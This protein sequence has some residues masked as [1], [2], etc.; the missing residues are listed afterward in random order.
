MNRI[1]KST[2]QTIESELTR[3]EDCSIDGPLHTYVYKH[4]VPHLFRIN[5]LNKAYQYLSDE[6][7]LIEM[8][9]RWNTCTVIFR[10]FNI[11]GESL[12]R[13]WLRKVKQNRLPLSKWIDTI[14]LF[15]CMDRYYVPTLLCEQLQKDPTIFTKVKDQLN[16]LHS[17]LTLYNQLAHYDKM[18]TVG[19]QI[20]A[21]VLEHPSFKQ[22]YQLTTEMNLALAYQ[23]QGDYEKARKKMEGLWRQRPEK[24][25]N[26]EDYL[27]L[28]L[29]LSNLYFFMGKEDKAQPMYEE[30]KKVLEE[31]NQT[32]SDLYESTLNNLGACYSALGMYEKSLALQMEVLAIY[33]NK[34]GSIHSSTAIC[35]YG[36]AKT[37][38]STDEPKKA[39]LYIREAIHSNTKVFGLQHEQTVSSIMLLG[40]IQHNLNLIDEAQATLSSCE[41]EANAIWSIGNVYMIAFNYNMFKVY[42]K[43]QKPTEALKYLHL[44]VDGEIETYGPDYK[45][46]DVSYWE[47][48][49]LYKSMD[50]WTKALMYA[51]K[52]FAIELKSEGFSKNTRVTGN[53]VVKMLI[54][55]EQYASILTLFESVHKQEEWTTRFVLFMAETIEK[56]LPN[57]YWSKQCL[58]FFEQNIG[59]YA[60]S[61]ADLKALW[62]LA[63]SSSTLEFKDKAVF[64]RKTCTDLCVQSYG[65]EN[66][67]TL[68]TAKQ[69]LQDMLAAGLTEVRRELIKKILNAVGNEEVESNIKELIHEIRA[70]L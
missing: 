7:F 54:Q 65:W 16:G 43:Q 55:Q 27:G 17:C 19:Q 23:G 38:W 5:D 13:T 70:L 44:C 33:K 39:E 49:K 67:N 37:F 42:K 4:A 60:F 58:A 10:C 62:K 8:H 24:Y 45:D 66:E 36:L 41:K 1:R 22:Q 47:L 50:N 6:E 26:D 35:L 31:S 40:R 18:I 64:Y 20:L 69:C 29:N 32:E 11:I 30:L 28:S 2:I 51:D 68:L 63:D 12:E 34:F 56:L 3:F 15:I 61:D 48:Y 59:T 46:L 9:D 52:C 53:A 25:Q 57:Q 14:D 21:L